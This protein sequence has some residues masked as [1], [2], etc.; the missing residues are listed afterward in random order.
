MAR[1]SAAWGGGALG[2]SNM[3]R[4]DQFGG[5]SKVRVWGLVVFMN[6]HMYMLPAVRNVKN[7]YWIIVLSQSY[8]VNAILFLKSVSM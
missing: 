6:A 2:G 4:R 8:Y 5:F 1:E 3:R 7:P